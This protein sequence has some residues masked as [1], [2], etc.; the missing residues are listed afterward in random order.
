MVGLLPLS[1]RLLGFGSPPFQPCLGFAWS[2]RTAAGRLLFCEPSQ[3][4]AG[5]APEQAIVLTV[6]GIENGQ[7][8]SDAPALAA[9][10]LLLHGLALLAAIG[11]FVAHE[12]SHFYPSR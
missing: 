10:L 8:R 9:S 7:R 4:L 1:H 11:R 5:V 2:A 3:G 6:T 12:T